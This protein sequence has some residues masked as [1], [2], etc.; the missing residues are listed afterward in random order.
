MVPQE[1]FNS[2]RE[3]NM[4]LGEKLS[5][6]IWTVRACMHVTSAGEPMPCSMQIQSELR[7]SS[8]TSLKVVDRAAIQLALLQLHQVS[9]LP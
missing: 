4:R 3:C 7:Q 2:L 9:T 1:E 8:S 6:S 5:H